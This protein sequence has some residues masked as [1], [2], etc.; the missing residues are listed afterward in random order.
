MCCCGAI[1]DDALAETKQARDAA[2]DKLLDVSAAESL[3][4]AGKTD[5]DRREAVYRQVHHW[6]PVVS[7]YAGDFET[8]WEEAAARF[9]RRA[10]SPGGDSN[11]ATECAVFMT[12]QS[13][14]EDPNAGVILVIR[15]T[16]EDGCWR[17]LNLGFTPDRRTLGIRPVGESQ[18]APN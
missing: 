8:E 1:R 14:D 15:L 3:A 2:I 12:L 11:T 16:Q 18:P 4:G 10:L 13:P 5:A 17:V 9:V 7:H 6:T